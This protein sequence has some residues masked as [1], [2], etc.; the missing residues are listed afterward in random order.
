MG[1]KGQ[2]AQVDS[3]FP[4]HRPQ[5]SPQVVRCAAVSFCWPILYIKNYF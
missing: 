5:D 4:T 2:F 1:I 3:L